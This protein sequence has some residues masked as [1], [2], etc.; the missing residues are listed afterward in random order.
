[1]NAG[2]TGEHPRASAMDAYTRLEKEGN[3]GDPRASAMRR[4]NTGWEGSKA[5][6]SSGQWGE[7]TSNKNNG[8]N[9]YQGGGRGTPLP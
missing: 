8:K 6:D 2:S 9:S 3:K 5:N 7:E 1:V 4:A